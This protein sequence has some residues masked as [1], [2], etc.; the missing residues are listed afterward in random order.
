VDP[1][2]DLVGGRRLASN[3]V[4]TV[5]A[6]GALLARRGEG[7]RMDL[8]IAELVVLQALARGTADVGALVGSTAAELRV[9]PGTVAAIVRALDQR[10]LLRTEATAPSPVVA[11]T[12]P[13]PA[14]VAA[15]P[16]IDPQ[17]PLILMTPVSFR[18]TPEGFTSV[19]HDGRVG[20]V[21][22]PRELHALVGFS[23][24]ATPAAALDAHRA[25]AGHLALEPSEL[26][27]LLARAL[28]SGG[29]S[30]FDPARPGHDVGQD[31]TTLIMRAAI[32]QDVRVRA[33]TAARVEQHR[34]EAEEHDA[35]TGR[36]R[37]PVVPIHQNPM[38]PP[39]G[40]AMVIAYAKELDG[41]RLAE[42]YDFRPE[43]L[44]HEKPV[45]DL[46]QEPSVF[47]VSN[48]IWSHRPNLDLAARIKAANPSCVMVH[49]G[50]DTPKYR[51]D[52]IE[53]FRINP[54]VDVA[55]HVEGE[56]TTAEMLDALVGCVGDG[57]PD[58]SRLHDVAG[59]SFR[60]GDRIVTTGERGRLED[61]DSIPSPYLTGLF[62]NYGDAPVTSITIE[63]NRGC[64]YGCTFCDWGSATMSRIRKFDLD[65]VF[66]ELEWAATRG[67]A[68]IGF[69]DANFGILERDVA[70]AEKVAELK[71]TYGFP[72]HCGTNYAKNTVKHLNKIVTTWVDAGIVT[73][74]MLSL[75]T[76]DTGTLTTIRRS[77]I[78][79]EK[80]DALADE[81]RRADLPLFVDL[82]MGLPGQTVESFRR[83]LQDTLER[84][85]VAKIHTTTL[86][87]NSPMNDPEY[88]ALH[89]IEVLNDTNLGLGNRVDNTVVSSSTFTRDDY[90]LMKDIRRTFLL[91]E[92]FGVL[93]HVAR[94]VRHETGRLEEDLYE[95]VARVA[96]TDPERWPALDFVVESASDVMAPPVSWR[97]FIDEV[98][99]LLVDE[100]GLPDD[101]A[102]QTVLAA[103]HAL[104]PAPDRTFPATV[105][106]P[107]DYAAWHA[108]M[109][110][111]KAAVGPDWVDKVPRLATFPPGEL[112]V[113]DRHHVSTQGLGY[114]IE[115]GW[116]DTWDLDSPV[117]RPTMVREMAS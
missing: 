16:E 104:L 54:H 1:I 34:K 2:A 62:D 81:F 102:L 27:G 116:L 64:P 35:R 56:A 29:L 12:P 25:G 17:V 85:V 72:K 82:M 41:G 94:F 42:Q 110:D 43:W 5:M 19:G 23:R 3:T 20:V 105:A 75:Q 93:R 86:L 78:K 47:L 117:A 95:T 100:L 65:R 46:A 33:T 63:T 22:G 89:R 40:L 112:V 69:A 109:L 101:P 71:A 32:Q 73:Q 92:N 48:Y 4:V 39:L 98:H 77:N 36:R 114:N 53:Y 108:A 28:A 87:V 107:H 68:G 79:T 50:P 91:L 38:V 37:V 55:V 6:A 90:S 99:R 97:L 51:G 61:L 45:E 59:L 66:A 13:A 111:A 15:A 83:D 57:P 11:L 70:I 106:L 115:Q 14:P 26:D 60:D 52:V 76:M 44:A 30:V 113:D 31:R 8:G 9:D 80:Y 58:L 24:S 7:D 103:Q 88:K 84:E 18:V 10:G 49:G 74:G 96:R 21:V 67:I